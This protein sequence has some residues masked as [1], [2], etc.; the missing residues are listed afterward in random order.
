MLTL[1]LV[2][3]ATWTS[4]P[5]HSDSTTIPADKPLYPRQIDALVYELHGLTEEENAIVE[6]ATG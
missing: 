4:T 3:A 2:R 6:E 5:A 1:F